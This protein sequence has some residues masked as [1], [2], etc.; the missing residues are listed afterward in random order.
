[1]YEIMQQVVACLHA[2]YVLRL[3]YKVYEMVA[4]RVVHN[5]IRLR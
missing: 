2:E 5:N 1:M 3:Q 4:Y